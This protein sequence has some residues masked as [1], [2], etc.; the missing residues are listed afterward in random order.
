M[1]RREAEKLSGRLVLL[2]PG[3]WSPDNYVGEP[4]VLIGQVQ[5]DWMLVG[6]ADG[7][8]GWPLG[9]GFNRSLFG[10]AQGCTRAWGCPFGDLDL[11]PIGA[12]VARKPRRRS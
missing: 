12:A 3:V 8:P 7:G 11:L 1:T 2:R 6:W 10:G 4:A 5:G 9:D